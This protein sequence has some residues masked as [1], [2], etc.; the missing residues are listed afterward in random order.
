[1]SPSGRFLLV[2]LCCMTLGAC[3]GAVVPE[4]SVP[5]ESPPR[6]VACRGTTAEMNGAAVQSTNTTRSRGGLAPL[7][8][9]MVLAE[10]AAEHACDMA[11]QGRMSHRGSTTSGPGDR[12]KARGYRPSLTA[13]NIAAGPYDQDQ[14]L[15]IWAG[16]GGHI[17]NIMIPQLRDFG[18]GH[19]IGLD[20]KTRYWSAVYAAPR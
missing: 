19:A 4:G 18:I 10:V 17:D 20:G 8:S 14:V 1:M 15:R 13:E 12:V 7:R 5:K 6:H 2:A 9:S 11:R 16:S 3:A